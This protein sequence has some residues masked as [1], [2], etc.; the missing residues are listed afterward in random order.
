MEKYLKYK[1]KYINLKNQIGGVVC[2]DD[3]FVQHYSECWHDSLLTAL[4]LSNE[5]GDKIQSIILEKEIDEIISCN[6]PNNFLLPLNID[7]DDL[8]DE[9]YSSKNFECHRVD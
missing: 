4:L 2:L 7:Y 8:N 1:N 5:F 9:E 6:K 3:G